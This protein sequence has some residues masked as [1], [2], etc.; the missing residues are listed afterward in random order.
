MK[1]YL[2]RKLTILLGA[3]TAVLVGVNCGVMGKGASTLTDAEIDAMARRVAPAFAA[4]GAEPELPRVFLDT[5]YVPPSGRTIAV[6]AGGDFQAAINQA[7][8]GDI[9][10]LQAGATFTGNFKL[11]AKT[12]TGWIV[13]RTS[14]PDSSLPAPGTRITPAYASVLPKIVTANAEP[15]I[16]AL[17][18]AHHYRLIGLE[19]TLAS[20]TQ[21]TY[22]LVGLGD[23]QNSLAQM[24][25]N[26]ILD[27]VYLHGNP[28]ATLRR[29]IRLNSASTA[30]ID[31][32][33]S[34]CH[35]VGNDSQAIGG[36]NGAGPF[37]IVNNYLEGAGENF[38]LGGGDPAVPNLV[39]S[40][41]EFR[42][43][44]CFKPLSWRIGNPS[45]AGTPW[46]VK[47]LFEL[48][49]A[50]RVLVD[51]NIFEHN[52]TMAQNGYA[53]L[54]TVRNQD[55]SAP[56]SVVQDVTFTNN[57]VRKSGAGINMHGTDNLQPS[58]ASRRFRI[59]N[60][61]FVEID[62]QRWE[63]PG[64]GFQL[65]GGPH[66][67]TVEHNTIIHSGSIVVTSGAPTEAL[68]FRNNLF[69]H[70]EY[71]VK[72]DSRGTGNETIT[73]YFPGIEFRKNILAGGPSGLYPPDN[74][75]PASLDQVGFV[76]RVNGNYRLTGSSPYKN[77]GTDGKDIGCDFNA[78]E[79]A[80][81]RNITPVA[82]VSAASYAVGSSLAA[83]SIVSAFGLGLSAG[84]LAAPSVPLPTILAGTT[85]KVRDSAGTERLAPLFY[86][87]PTQVNYQLPPGTAAGAAIVTV[88]SGSDIVAAGAVQIVAVA[89]GL[90]T[91]EA[92]GRGVAAGEA[93]RF[94]GSAQ[95]AMEPLAR[96]DAAQGR[97]IPV[98]VDLSFTTDQV[99]LT[100]Y[101]TGFRLRNPNGTV[102]ARVGDVA[103]QV[104]YAGTQRGFEGL[105]QANILLPNSLA[106]R[107]TVNV[108]VTID[109]QDANTVSVTI[110]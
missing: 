32:Y 40:D 14:A 18:G 3:L 99:F 6:A 67:V 33:L 48:K 98:P 106:G 12:G 110:K 22:N 88:T 84:T 59:S 27:R 86:V 79:A 101:G 95:Q 65:I 78:L 7:L 89:P 39:M 71:G 37:K 51:G 35:E 70:N 109:G 24:P 10:T 49:N 63:G 82:S 4:V 15:A 74:F 52:W 56:W 54:F 77:A 97:W 5:T 31:S 26:L 96:F 53:I 62:G 28:T 42:R 34:D 11:P 29:A 81:V 55:G 50:Q 9:I 102:T 38:I 108:V 72:G 93:T 57:I 36:W 103:C 91:F 1:T 64:I 45:Y 2:K 61:L 30:V 8:P 68:V 44:H 85:V 23:V 75:F 17:D 105:D 90:F 25:H 13:I 20:G 92:T 41:I 100:L 21:T 66:E 46:G 47:N 107:G 60:N 16:E 104:T 58:V 83:E 76:D 87:S 73:T 94:R 19:C 80:L 69:A 43:N